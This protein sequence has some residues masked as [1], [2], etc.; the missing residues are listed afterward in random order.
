MKQNFFPSI[1]L[2][3]LHFSLL[4]KKTIYRVARAANFYVF[5]AKCLYENWEQCIIFKSYYN[6][7]SSKFKEN[8]GKLS[9]KIF[10]THTQ[11]AVFCGC[12]VTAA[13]VHFPRLCVG[14]DCNF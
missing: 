6:L 2:L 1:L 9:N 7:K 12:F 5:L 10:F 11:L 4:Y 14:D 8:E 3:K 13:Y